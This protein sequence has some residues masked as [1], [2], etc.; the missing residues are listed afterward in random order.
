MNKLLKVGALSTA[1]LA[2]IGPP[3]HGRAMTGCPPPPPGEF[4]CPV[5][6]CERDRNSGIT[7]RCAHRG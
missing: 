1:T 7:R 2:G 5:R 4:P 6:V 3:H